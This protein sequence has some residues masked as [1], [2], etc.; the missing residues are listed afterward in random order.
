MQSFRENATRGPGFGHLILM[1]QTFIRGDQVFFEPV[2]RPGERIEYRPRSLVSEALLEA[3]LDCHYWKIL[4]M[5]THAAELPGG[6]AGES[7]DV[8][9]LME[10]RWIPTYTPDAY[11]QFAPIFVQGLNEMRRRF[12]RLLQLF[13]HA[14]PKDYQA[15]LVRAGRQ[16]S[17]EQHAYVYLPHM[18]GMTSVDIDLNL[19]FRSRFVGVINVLR[20]CSRE[21]DR[22]R[23][24]LGP[25]V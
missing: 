5:N 14:L 21:A 13:Q 20:R 22:R 17:V 1:A 16:L 2:P 11:K 9:D 7:V 19:M 25:P 24:E 18:Q 12:D 15:E 10:A 8:W 6:A 3:S 23:D 4:L